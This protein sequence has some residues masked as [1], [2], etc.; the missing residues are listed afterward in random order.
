M[1]TSVMETGQR[2]PDA[3]SCAAHGFDVDYS[4]R[5]LA[6]RPPWGELTLVDVLLNNMAL[7]LFL[8]ALTGAV[9]APEA[10][11][12]ALPPAFVL[13]WLFLLCDLAVLVLDL[14]D[15]LRFHHMLRT[16]RPL[17]PMWIGVWALTASAVGMTFPALW[18]ILKTALAA[19]HLPGLRE[20]LLARPT[21]DAL[22]FTLAAGVGWAAAPFA[23]AG[24]VYKGVL[25]SATSQAI[26]GRARWFPAYITSGAILVGLAL[27][28]LLNLWAETGFI[29]PLL[30]AMLPLLVGDALFLELELRPLLRRAGLGREERKAR[31]A[32]AF[33]GLVV[34][35]LA[36][37][38]FGGFSGMWMLVFFWPGLAG[39]LLAACLG[40][41]AF[42][43]AGGRPSRELRA[44]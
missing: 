35:C 27:F 29:R 16:V 33:D 30:L 31:L 11:G 8:I 2:P 23:A 44:E 13:A 26:W 43:L 40:R 42:L 15:P 3:S 24:L 22:L 1:N 5:P 10:V 36:A 18:G 19:G 41:A 9:L 28:A 20:A 37:V 25:F 7:G 38:V 32:A 39:A 4:G 17:S 14:G 34:L 6:R 12:A 21:E